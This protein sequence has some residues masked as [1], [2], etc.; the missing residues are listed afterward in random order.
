MGS[1]VREYEYQRNANAERRETMVSIR[2]DVYPDFL[3]DFRNLGVI[4][5]MLVG[6]NVVALAAA[7]V[8]SANLVEVADRFMR[9]ASIVEPLLLASMVAL[10]ALSTLLARLPYRVG[11][12][13]VVTVILAL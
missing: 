8:G 10:S 7:A 9:I 4:A 6:V 12:A 11:A 1:R 3:P 5:R 2:Q 13:G